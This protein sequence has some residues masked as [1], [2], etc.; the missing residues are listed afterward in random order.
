M[1]LGLLSCRLA[2]RIRTGRGHRLLIGFTDKQPVK[3]LS[4][5][6][7][8]RISIHD[9]LGLLL[10]AARS[11][12]KELLIADPGCSAPYFCSY[13][14][15][16][17]FICEIAANSSLETRDKSPLPFLLPSSSSAWW[18]RSRISCCRCHA[19]KKL[20]YEGLTLKRLSVSDQEH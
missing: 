3:Q 1:S 7:C 18:G 15:C 12:P 16:A 20:R 14:Y 9:Q 17:C 5:K 2:A 11:R 6:A 19:R 8:K 4:S 13:T 10:V